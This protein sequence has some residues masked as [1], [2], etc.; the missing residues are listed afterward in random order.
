MVFIQDMKTRNFRLFD[1]VGI[2]LISEQRAERFRI[3]WEV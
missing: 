1:Y 3:C 2:E